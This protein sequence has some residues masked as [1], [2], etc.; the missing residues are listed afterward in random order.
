[1][2]IVFEQVTGEVAPER[3][4]PTHGEPAPTPEGAEDMRAKMLCEL[5]L[6]IERQARVFAD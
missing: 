4:A 5:A 2:P 6:L 3:N 1:M